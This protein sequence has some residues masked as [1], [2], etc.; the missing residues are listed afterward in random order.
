MVPGLTTV[1]GLVIHATLLGDPRELLGLGNIYFSRL[2]LPF[3]LLSPKMIAFT[4]KMAIKLP[5]FMASSGNK[6][7]D[8]QRPRTIHASKSFSK[9][10]PASPDPTNRIQRASTIQNGLDSQ[11]AMS[12]K[13][14]RLP[15]K[16]ADAFEKSSEEEEE[17]GQTGEAS[18]K[19]PS[20]FD[21]LPIELVS[22][23]DRSDQKFPVYYRC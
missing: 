11:G 10:A 5:D 13:S 22:L 12:D 4:D 23:T 19:L 1:S 21:E 6:K 9:L 16:Q 2:L 3:L 7:S 17:Q 14:Q 18:G 20:D 8:T 15:Q